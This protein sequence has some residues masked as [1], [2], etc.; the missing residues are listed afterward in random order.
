MPHCGNFHEGGY[1]ATDFFH[2][3]EE[4]EGARI[5]FGESFLEISAESEMASVNHERIYVAPD[6]V[7]IR[8]RADFAI[9][10]R[11]R[12]NRYVGANSRRARIDDGRGGRFRSELVE[13]ERF[14]VRVR[15]NRG[16]AL[17]RIAELIHQAQAGHRVF[18]VADGGAVLRGDFQLREFFRERGAADQ[19]RNADSGFAKICGGGDHLLRAL[20]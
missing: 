10:I 17:R 1:F 5:A 2:V 8:N 19:K 14:D 16:V 4:F 11:D 15:L 12:R 18:C 13:R 6:F 7:Q 9:E 3:V 20:H